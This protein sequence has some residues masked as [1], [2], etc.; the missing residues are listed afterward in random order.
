MG[1]MTNLLVKDDASTRVEFV[2][3]PV[4]DSGNTSLWRASVPGTPFEGQVRMTLSE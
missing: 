2:L 1:A 3:L 4:A